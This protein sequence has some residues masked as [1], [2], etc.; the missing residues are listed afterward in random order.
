MS[1]MGELKPVAGLQDQTR[2]ELVA[3]VEQ[4]IVLCTVVSISIIQAWRRVDIG[5]VV[6]TEV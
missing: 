5:E 6:R 4:D 3:V 2:C 1:V